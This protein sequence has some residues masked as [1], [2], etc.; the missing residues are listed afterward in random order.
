M[1]INNLSNAERQQIFKKSFKRFQKEE[2]NNSKKEFSRKLGISDRSIITYLNDKD[3]SI[4][5]IN[6]MKL[7]KLYPDLS[8]NI[9]NSLNIVSEPISE[10]NKSLGTPFYDTNLLNLGKLNDFDMIL[11][12][13]PSM[14]LSDPFLSGCDVAL[15]YEA[16]NMQGK[17]GNGISKGS[18]VG[19]RELNM[20]D[21]IFQPGLDYLLVGKKFMF[22][23]TVTF[24]E[25]QNYVCSSY[26]SEYQ[27]IVLER[28][29]V[30]K[31]YAVKGFINTK[32]N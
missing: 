7:L 28:S 18:I 23:Y 3:T 4:S 5:D 15:R 8:D 6:F 13:T 20:S 1:D 2:V 12:T 27:T 31:I 9:T 16:L 24:D 21:D 26:N 30:L 25:H 29:K 17:N 14:L 32:F 11:T 22:I 19:L 10:Y